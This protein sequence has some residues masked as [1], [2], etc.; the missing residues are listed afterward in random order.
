[1]TETLWQRIV[2]FFRGSGSARAASSASAT[3]PAKPAAAATAPAAAASRGR[4]TTAARSK[5]GTASRG[6][7][8]RKPASKAGAIEEL[9]GIGPAYGKK[10]RAAGIATVAALLDEGAQSKGRAGIVERT[11]L[12]HDNVLTWVNNADLMRVNGVT[13]QFAELLQL[14]GVDSPLE[15]ANR[16]AANLT[17]ALRDRNTAGKRHIVPELPSDEAVAGWIASAK[18]LE[19]RVFH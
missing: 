14:A 10:L 7:A 4:S 2:A 19:K 13:P 18:K 16:N 17:K 5:S 3:A 8:K 1:M 12:A 11:G 6:A 15:L 9:E